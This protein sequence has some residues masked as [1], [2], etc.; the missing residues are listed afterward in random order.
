MKYILPLFALL[1]S[2]VALGMH[3]QGSSQSLLTAQEVST[4]Y[5]R[6][7][8][9]HIHGIRYLRPDYLGMAHGNSELAQDIQ[10]L[11][12]SDKEY[13][14]VIDQFK[15]VCNKWKL[16]TSAVQWKDYDND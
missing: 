5:H 3:E 9:L 8:R 11:H 4:I 16:D 6:M 10:K 14:T 1:S 12:D 2:P 7:Y 15:T 13:E